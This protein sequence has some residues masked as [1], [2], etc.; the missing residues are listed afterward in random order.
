[1]DTRNLFIPMLAGD[2]PVGAK[3][4]SY[5]QR[6]DGPE[7][8]L[9]EMLDVHAPDRIPGA[10][11]APEALVTLILRS[12]HGGDP[13]ATVLKCNQTITV[14]GIGLAVVGSDS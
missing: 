1:M 2:V 14:T 4:V 7:L 9:L 11:H 6:G 12:P 3:L 5:T 10:H 8:T 13:Y